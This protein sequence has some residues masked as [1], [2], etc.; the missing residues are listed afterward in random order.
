MGCAVCRFAA[1]FCLL[2]VAGAAS[3]A[4]AQVFS[5]IILP[6]ER[7]ITVRDPSQLPSIPIPDL[8]PPETVSTFE[9]TRPEQP[10]SLDEAIRIALANSEVIRVLAGVGAASSGT[11]I[12]DPAIASTAIDQQRARFDPTLDIQNNFNRFETPAAIFDP[13]DPSQALI[14]G[15]RTD[16]YNFDMALTKTNVHGGQSQL[17][18]DAN[19]VRVQPGNLPLNPQTRSS[20]TLAY[21]QPLLQGAGV[22]ANMVPIVVAR[23]DTERSY[24]QFK[25]S[26]QELVRGVVDAY[27]GLVFART[28]VWARRKQVEQLEFTYNRAQRASVVGSGSAGD[29]AQSRVALENF[30][31]NLIAAEAN[32]LNSEAAL[33]NLLGIP[34]TDPVD[35]VPITPP[36]DDLLRFDW[37]AIAALAEQRRPDL[38]ELKLVLEADQQLLIQAENEALPSVDAVMLYRWNGLEGEM[39][40]GATIS[41]DGG[42]F[43]DWTLG[44]NFS[45]PLGLRQSR[46][47]LRRQELIITRDRANIE[48]GLHAALHTLAANLRNLDQFYRQYTRFRATR[49]AAL[50]NI[51]QQYVL[52]REGLAD[53]LNVLQAIADWGNAVS[54]EAQS[55]A[56]YNVELANLERQ[57]GTILETHGIRFMEERF[58][59][60]GPL[61]RM[62]SPR[63]Y[64]AAIVPLPNVELYPPGN[65][66][67]EQFFQLDDPL[68][69]LNRA[70]PPEAEIPPPPADVLPEETLPPMPGGASAAAP[71]VREAA[72]WMKE[73]GAGSVRR[74]VVEPLPPVR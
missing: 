60:I 13:L 57:T 29:V 62:H 68:E 25:D 50:I 69:R 55:L 38:I 34:P 74:P 16:D 39:P 45:V 48:Q 47:N 54:A 2:V 71:T 31:A 40:S 37:E 4:R 1:V 36:T 12:Y 43:T 27:W 44:V 28:D 5:R 33:R 9:E 17:L 66:A 61:G 15:A 22:A 72:H 6:E 30:R 35:F 8:P 23:I 42:Q 20:V 59:S 21:T 14:A 46:A 24:F 41:T 11:T 64:P 51:D 53:Q 73:R 56:Q 58:G 49:Q 70:Q 18:V 3:F 63:Y 32:L 52:F 19:P 67:A 7:T 65:E 10:L 26:A